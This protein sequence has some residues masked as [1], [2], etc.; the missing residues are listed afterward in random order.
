MGVSRLIIAR[1]GDGKEVAVGIVGEARGPAQRIENL[2]EP[3]QHVVIVDIRIAE[4]IK[5]V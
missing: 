4:R 1:V 3:V 2:G 5:S